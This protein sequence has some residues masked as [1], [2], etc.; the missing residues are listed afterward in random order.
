MENK[1]QRN[2]C[3]NVIAP[4]PI[5]EYPGNIFHIDILITNKSNFLTAIDNFSK[6]AVLVPIAS[7]NAVDIKTALFQILN[8]FENVKL[9]VSDNERSFKSSLI[10]AFLRDYYG[11]EQH[12]VPPM[13]SQSN[14]QVETFHSTLLEIARCVKAQQNIGD[15]V[16]LLLLSTLKYNNTIHSVTGRKPVD[17]INSI[18][19]K[20]L[21]EIKAK[22]NI[23]QEKTLRTHN[24]NVSF[25]V[26]PGDRVFVRR[27][28]RLG[29]KFDKW[30]VEGTIEQ[31]LGSTVLINK[32]SAQ[33]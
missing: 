5:P 28:Q 3:N 2:P 30:Y 9:V 7:R 26:H 21:E 24:E 13:H 16:E 18:P 1:Y 12:F 33:E 20:D 15:T 11:A 25:K 23:A 14:G 6:F 10:G 8:R 27:N 17:I 4:T 29:N 19:G 32:K 31:D 22:L